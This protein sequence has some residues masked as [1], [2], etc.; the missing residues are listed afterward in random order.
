VEVGSGSGECTGRG[1][2]I[3]GILYEQ[4]IYF[5]LK[6]K[7]EILVSSKGVSLKKQTT[8]KDRLRAQQ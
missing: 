2:Y 5:Q 3:Q 8:L 1:N 4:R 6:G 7:K